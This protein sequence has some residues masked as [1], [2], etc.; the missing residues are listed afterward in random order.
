MD[1]ETIK[2]IVFLLAIVI[3]QI[4]LV[5]VPFALK[6]QQDGREFDLNYAYTAFIGFVVMA[7]GAM[8]SETIMNMPLEFMSV[9]YLAFGGAVIQGAVVGRVTPKRIVVMDA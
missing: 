9:M 2:P 6:Q 3:G 8:A 4:L 1:T 7:V 5:Y